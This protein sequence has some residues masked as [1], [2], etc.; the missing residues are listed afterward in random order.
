[1][2][3]HSQ[4][5]SLKHL[6]AAITVIE[7]LSTAGTG[8]GDHSSRIVSSNLSSKLATSNNESKKGYKLGQSY[9]IQLEI[10]FN[11][12]MALKRVLPQTTK[13]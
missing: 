5:G 11:F 1:M 13:L 6:S 8:F 4:P 2:L 12:F 3:G 9:S 10:A 7:A